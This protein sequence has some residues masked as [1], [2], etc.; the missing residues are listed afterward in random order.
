MICVTINTLQFQIEDNTYQ[1]KPYKLI[2][3]AHH[4]LVFFYDEMADWYIVSMDIVPLPSKPTEA[5]MFV[6]D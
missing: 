2:Y 6:K 5:G 1:H 3:N 4:I